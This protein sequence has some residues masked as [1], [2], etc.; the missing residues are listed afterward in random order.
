MTSRHGS[1]ARWFF[2]LTGLFT[3]WLTWYI[4]PFQSPDET[5]HLWR[6]DMISR[7][8]LFLTTQTIGGTSGGYIDANLQRIAKRFA[9]M[10]PVALI[11]N[12]PAAAQVIADELPSRWSGKLIFQAAAGTGYYSPLIY[13]PHATA[14]FVGRQLDWSILHTYMLV[15]VTVIIT[16]FMLA[17]AALSI[18]QPNPL[19]MV[20]LMT[21][22]ALFQWLSSTIDGLSFGL[23]LL[24]LALWSQMR[25]P[26]STQQRWLPWS[27]YAVLLLLASTRTNLIVLSALPLISYFKT[28][29]IKAI[30]VTALV[31]VILIAWTA[32]ATHGIV[33]DRVVRPQSTVQIAELYLSKPWEFLS[34]M[35][36]TL[37]SEKGTWYIESFFGYFGWLTIPMSKSATRDM[38][39]VL[40]LMSVLLISINWRWR[41][42]IIKSLMIVLAL[43]SCV[44]V[45]FALAISWNPYPANLIEGV[46]GR[47]FII[48]AFLLA[49]ALGPVSP[50][51]YPYRWFEV[52]LVGLFAAY[53][54]HWLTKTLTAAYQL[55][56]FPLGMY[57]LA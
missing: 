46:Q 30:T 52:L 7:G 15:R 18:Y 34:L 37:H 26:E 48:P 41:Q 13:L 16:A 32:I 22:M 36:R 12:A 25:A 56:A 11:P 42:P 28:D 49:Y 19:A 50:R 45:F 39:R 14:L 33:D 10:P 6:A 51:S 44:L 23:A 24:L 53:S 20:C 21:P 4:P 57:L 55:P 1:S 54:I 40:L 43:L 5:A 3:L 8:Q 35:A 38:W 31:S 47:Y 27:F 2:A 9:E 29:K 17:C